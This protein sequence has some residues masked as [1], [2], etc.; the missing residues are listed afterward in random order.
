[1]TGRDIGPGLP[2][3]VSRRAAPP[4]ASRGI[5][6][7]ASAREKHP[8]APAASP[9]AVAGAEPPP[10][11]L[12]VVEQQALIEPVRDLVAFMLS[13]LL[14]D[15]EIA[16]GTPTVVLVNGSGGTTQMELLTV[17]GE[18]AA[19]LAARGIPQL[20]PMIGSYSTTQ[21]TAGFSISLFTPTPRM[22]AFWQAPHGAPFFP[23]I[24]A[25]RGAG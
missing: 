6:S 18:V 7:A 11:P 1:M 14:G 4:A 22:L 8:A 10:F 2:P 17:F 21:E 12:L 20:S 23:A 3:H 19:G 13:E 15:R 16:A 25:P 24:S 9:H 5:A